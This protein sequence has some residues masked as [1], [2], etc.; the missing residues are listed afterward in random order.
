MGI[1]QKIDQGYEYDPKTERLVITGIVKLTV[2]RPSDPE[3]PFSE[4]S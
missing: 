1:S 4:V 2:Y 3:N